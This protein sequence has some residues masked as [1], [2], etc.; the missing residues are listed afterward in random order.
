LSGALPIDGA[1]PPRPGHL[2]LY[3]HCGVLR[4]YADNLTLRELTREELD[5][6]MKDPSMCRHSAEACHPSSECRKLAVMR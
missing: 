6:V 2:S 4:I 3:A 5:D 1:G